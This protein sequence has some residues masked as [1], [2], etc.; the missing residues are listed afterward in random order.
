[1]ANF[2]AV[3]T[4]AILTE[5]DSVG[6]VKHLRVSVVGDS[7]YVAGGSVGFLKALRTLMGNRVNV[8]H[9]EG[10]GTNKLGATPE[11]FEYTPRGSLIDIDAA[12]VVPG[13]DLIT[14]KTAHGLSSG[15]A[16]RFFKKAPH[17]A[18]LP[19][20]IMPTGLAEDTI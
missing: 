17:N 7:A 20:P 10:S 5:A 19:D 11:E 1:M 4:V 6:P 15:N 3:G 14:S 13:T 18:N 9:S 16:V 12:A 8:I 2:G